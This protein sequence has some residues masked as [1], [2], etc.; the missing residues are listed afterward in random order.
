MKALTP[1]CGITAALVV[2]IYLSSACISVAIGALVID[3][4][5][6]RFA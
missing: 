3:F 5:C 1:V 6:G 4:L 2:T